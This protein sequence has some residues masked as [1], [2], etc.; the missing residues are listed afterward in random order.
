MGARRSHADASKAGT[1]LATESSP[2][3]RM[4]LPPGPTTGSSSFCGGACRTDCATTATRWI[5]AV[6]DL[7]CT[8]SD[9]GGRTLRPCTRSSS[10]EHVTLRSQPNGRR[11]RARR[12]MAEGP[13]ETCM[14]H[15]WAT[16]HEDR[17]M[18]DKRP[19]CSIP[20]SISSRSSSRASHASS[21]SRLRA[22]CRAPGARRSSASGTLQGSASPSAT[23][24]RHRR[25]DRG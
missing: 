14:L 15:A 16:R 11:P 23:H 5:A 12:P 13:R 19:S 1:A 8:A 20:E 17:A 21:A 7:R 9:A 4:E 2:S 10:P 24:P 18:V 3:A 25:G 6:S 22:R